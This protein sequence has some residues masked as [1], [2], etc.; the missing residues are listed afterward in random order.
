MSRLRS[1][2]NIFTLSSLS[3][4]ACTI[5]WNKEEP[6]SKLKELDLPHMRS[7]SF[8][9]DLLYLRK[10]IVKYKRLPAINSDRLLSGGFSQKLSS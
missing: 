7:T 8:F 6:S 3:D 5:L 2:K 4:E 1:D 10:K 9:S